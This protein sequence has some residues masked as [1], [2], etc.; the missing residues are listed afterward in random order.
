MTDDQFASTI[1]PRHKITGI[2]RQY[3][4]AASNVDTHRFCQLVLVIAAMDEQAKGNLLE[5][6]RGRK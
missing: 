2:A 6:L 1:D 4:N 3:A 5:E